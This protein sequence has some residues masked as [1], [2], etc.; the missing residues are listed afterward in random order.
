VGEKLKAARK[1]AGLTQVELAD[2]VGVT[3]RDVSRWETGRREPGVLT[4]KKMA[5]ALGCSM[6]DLV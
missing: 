2:K 5:Q 4:V 6:D 1:A 3:Q